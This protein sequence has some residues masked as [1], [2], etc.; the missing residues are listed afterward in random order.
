MSI[1]DSLEGRLGGRTRFRHLARPASCSSTQ[2]LADEIPRS[3]SLVVW[4]DRQTH[5]RGRRGRQWLGSAGLDVEATFRIVDLSIPR[6]TVLA[7]ALPT[8]LCLAIEELTGLST[9]LKWPNDI[10]HHGRKLC[11]ILIDARGNPPNHYLLGVGLN[12]NRTRFPEELREFATSLALAT[13]R[14][15]DRDLV[16]LALAE[17]IEACLCKISADQLGELETAFRDRLTCIGHDVEIVGSKFTTTAR[18]VDVDFTTVE[19]ADGRR[20]PLSTLNSL[21]RR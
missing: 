20:Y 11:G 9:E 17:A 15:Y 14:E 7:A 19:L 3:G 13:G 2:D 4:A 6:P 18:L 5:G 1:D 12:V 10:Q 16:F 21:Q 8:A